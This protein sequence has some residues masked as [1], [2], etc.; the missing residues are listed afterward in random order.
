M[1]CK[2]C[3]SE[4]IVK[5]GLR[6]SKPCFLCKNCGHQFTIEQEKYNKFDKYIVQ[7]LYSQNTRYKLINKFINAKL[8]ITHIAKIL[9]CNYTTLYCWIDFFTD[10][11]PEK[12]KKLLEYLKHR[13]NGKDICGLLFPNEVSFQP[14]ENLLSITKHKK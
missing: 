1:K 11:K 5:N 3:G 2:K 7:C 14:S 9:D 6:R 10:I 4:R 13:K 8:Q 12:S